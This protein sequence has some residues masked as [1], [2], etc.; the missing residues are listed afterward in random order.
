M[1]LE[2]LE[3]QGFKSFARKNVLV[4]PGM[5]SGNQRGIT[6][7]VG[8]NGSGKS[9]VADAVRWTLGEQSMK[10][11][12]GKKAEDVIFSGTEKKGKLGMAEV[13]LFLNNEDKKAPIDYSQVVITRRLYRDGNSEYM[14]NNN[15][16]RLSDIQM[17]LAKASFGQKTYSVIGQGMVE[18]FLNTSLAERKEFFDEATG[19]RQY[20]IKRDDALNKLKNSLENLHQAE[21]LVSEI[22]PRLKNLTRQVD[23]IQKREALEEELEEI[24]LKYYRKSWHDINDRLSEANQKYLEIEKEKLNRDQKIDLLNKKLDAIQQEKTV[25][26]A[27]EDL[28]A[29]LGRLNSKKSNLYSQLNKLESWLTI[30]EEKID[31]LDTKALEAKKEELLKANAELQN[32]ISANESLDNR[33]KINELED[34][35]RSLRNEREEQVRQANKLNAWLEMKL[36]SIGQFDLSFLNNRKTEINKELG[37]LKEELDEANNFIITNENELGRLEAEKEEVIAQVKNINQE[38]NEVKSIG[39]K[40]IVSEVN[41]RLQKSLDKLAS[42]EKEMDLQKVRSSLL[43]IRDELKKV[44]AF[45]TGKEAEKKIEK[46]QSELEKL[47]EKRE[48]LIEKINN[49]RLEINTKKERIR[50]I[51]SKQNQLEVELR[52]TN[53]KLE[54]SQEKFDS[55]SVKAEI[56]ELEQKIKEFDSKIEKTKDV[57]NKLHEKEEEAK[58]VSFNLQSELQKNQYEINQINERLNDYRI[59]SAKHETRLEDLEE[60]ISH[61]GFVGDISEE[62]AK[63]RIKEIETEIEEVDIKIGHDKEK[64]ERFN[65]EQE[66]KR[67]HLLSLQREIQTL[68][69]EINQLNLRLNDEKIKSTRYETR[70]EDLEVEIRQSFESLRPIKDKRH[71]EE[72][73]KEQVWQRIVQVKRQLDQI[74]GIDPEVE[75]EY[76]ETKERFDFLNGQAT[77]LNQTIDSLKGVVKELDVTIKEKFDKEFKIISQKF[78]EYFKILFN[79]GSAKIVKVLADDKEK[80]E[81]E[82]KQDGENKMDSNLKKIKFL[83]KNNSTGLAGIEIS[84]C[85]PG[86]KIGSVSML[87]GGERAL[88]AIA[89]ICAII[90]ANPSPFVVL[91]EVDAALDEA[92][93]ERL[94]KILDELSHKT[95]FIVITHNR[96]SMRRANILYGVTMGDDG[97]SKLLSVKLDEVKSK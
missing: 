96:A 43:E 86:K 84:A 23:K 24:Q 52:D 80:E 15:R 16:V 25:S 81:N 3:I 75:K 67:N 63:K 55:S 91:D 47:S 17:L 6:A 8:P 85:P 5:V 77:D 90:S 58:N 74:G 20:Q 97:V 12:R 9:N 38:L 87:S 88:T 71:E 73:D 70:L 72:I 48:G 21:M 44:L 54:K 36:E 56:A 35:L 1:F 76:K 49:I 61:S 14:I 89:L 41:E 10:T 31:E 7:V 22:E 51:S 39:N 79:G 46:I 59:S 50:L 82:L 2:K 13:S 32:K 92:N 93:S 37:E 69:Q 57:L 27:F 40:K 78:E 19:V 83:Q 53:G 11:L 29:N 66:K 42:A 30:K 62:S 95:Q 18:G 68:Q 34:A 60:A 65:M 94:A 4:F 45:S 64:I 28:Q 26:E 33:E